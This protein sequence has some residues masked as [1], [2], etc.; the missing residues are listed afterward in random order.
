MKISQI[1]SLIAFFVLI[2]QTLF[3]GESYLRY[4]IFGFWMIF[5]FAHLPL[6]NFKRIH[7]HKLSMSVI[8]L[9]L[10]GIAYTSLFTHSVP[11]TLDFW[12][13]ITTIIL[14]F[15]FFLLLPRNY[16]PSALFF[17]GLVILGV[18]FTFIG[19]FF[20]FFP[21]FG[22]KLP[23]MNIFYASF[24]HNHLVA[25]LLLLVPV[26]IGLLI[27]EKK[28]K[29]YWLLLLLLIAGIIL[30][31]GRTG[32]V[33]GG[34]E[35]IV[36]YYFYVKEKNGEAAKKVG[37]LVFLGILATL[38]IVTAIYFLFSARP[39]FNESFDC[40]GIFQRVKLCKNLQ[41][42]TR[43][44]YWKQAIT[45]IENFPVIGYGP[46]TF[47][48]ISY[49][50]QQ[51]PGMFSAFAHNEFLQQFAENGLIGGTLFLIMI[52]TLLFESVRN[53]KNKDQILEKMV[54]LAIIISIINASIDFDWSFSG[55]LL[56]TFV[57]FALLIRNERDSDQ[58]IHSKQI[59]QGTSKCIFII[60]CSI[61][62]TLSVL[63]LVTE[64]LLKQ[65]RFQ[66]AFQLFPYFSSQRLIFVKELNGEFQAKLFKIYFY[67][68]DVQS[69]KKDLT[70]EDSFH[71]FTLNPWQQSFKGVDV[72]DNMSEKHLEQ[73]VLF[74][75][76]AK[77]QHDY[78]LSGTSQEQ[79]SA[80][81][82]DR[83]DNFL[84]KNEYLHAGRYIVYAYRLTDWS[85][86]FHR[87]VF[88][89]HPVSMNFIDQFLNQLDFIPGSYFGAFADDYANLYLGYLNENES[90][91]STQERER[92]KNR[93][94][95]IAWWKEDVRNY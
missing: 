77:Y 45:A 20:F 85:L 32:F 21:H 9:Y 37:K 76:N 66:V 7:Q 14:T 39:V 1:G 8:C 41:K 27:Q 47:S 93:I 19:I 49:K 4:I 2:L 81:L 48:L 82:L 44:L 65:N 24:G 91:L 95:E 63:S 69:K 46:G 67:H 23:G 83:A 79:I 84:L 31:F 11:L 52:A 10:I 64:V 70:Q 86:N 90:H 72:L 13:S 61:I 88:I 74:L 33:L 62:L 51:Y 22:S 50:Y 16:Y 94:L 57:F 34:V 55:I 73:Y 40:N 3:F 15:C 6:F 53:L 56:L 12:A 59:L 89:D 18:V 43:L 36:G 38:F 60:T 75:L 28:N 26:L 80:H 29:M 17:Q 71:L 42:E 25:L 30:S 68:E 92:L 87:P 58:P 5:I 78:Q 35:V 54:L